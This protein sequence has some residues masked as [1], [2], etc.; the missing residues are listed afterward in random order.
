MF[1]RSIPHLDRH[2]SL[3]DTQTLQSGHR[4]EHGANSNTFASDAAMDATLFASPSCSKCRTL[5]L[6]ARA[7]FCCALRKRIV[8]SCVTFRRAVKSSCIRGGKDDGDQAA[9]EGT[10][11]VRA[12]DSVELREGVHQRRLKFAM[13]YTLDALRRRPHSML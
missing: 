11:L 2:L 13:S 8:A 5:R 6:S 7:L 10:A 4:R 1:F 9:G 12:H 3:L